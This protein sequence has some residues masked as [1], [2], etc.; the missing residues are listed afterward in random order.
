MKGADEECLRKAVATSSLPLR[1]EFQVLEAD[2][3]AAKT[4][5]GTTYNDNHLVGVLDRNVGTKDTHINFGESLDPI[6]W[7][8]AEFHCGKADLCIVLGTSM[9][10]RHVTHFPFMARKTVIVNLQSTPDDHRCYNGLRIWGTCDDVLRMLLK[11]M[12][13]P[14]AAIDEDLPLW[15]PHH[16]VRIQDLEK[17]GIPRKYHAIARHIMS[18]YGWPPAH[19][20]NNMTRATSEDIDHR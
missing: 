11:H 2:S 4:G 6:D 18:R 12:D 9:S 14:Q 8:E 10:L 20:Y 3:Q 19:L 5:G 16:A 7:K 15:R 17:Q 1:F 13:I